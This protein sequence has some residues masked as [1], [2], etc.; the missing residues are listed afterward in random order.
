MNLSLFEVLFRR[1]QQN[2]GLE[3]KA[4]AKD[5]IDFLGSEKSQEIEIA[6]LTAAWK[7]RGIRAEELK[8]LSDYLI[9]QVRANSQTDPKKFKLKKTAVL[10]C[11]GTGG[12][13]SNTFNISTISAI[14]AASLGCKIVKHGGRRTTS[15]TGSIDLLEFLSVPVQLNFESTEEQLA[16]KNL[17]FIASPALHKLLGH[18]KIICQKLEIPGQ[19]GLLGTLSNPIELD[20]QVLGVAKPELVDLLASTLQLTQRKKALVIHGEPKLDEASIAGKTRICQVEAGRIS[21][22]FEIDP[23]ELGLKKQG[24]EKIR[25][26]S[27]GVNA[28]ILAKIL[29]NRASRGQLEVVLLNAG[30]IVWTYGLYNSLESSL[31]ACEKA[32]QEKRVKEFFHSKVQF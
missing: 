31:D 9:S 5:F 7:M 14:V 24:L 15:T 2:Q 3:Q 25:G 21:Q 8:S 32:I 10:D 26:G 17:L 27:P 16:E 30:L 29:D 23:A 11:C 20:Y 18:W 1:F 4:F 12:D 19:T 13:L 22:D 28:R 6:A